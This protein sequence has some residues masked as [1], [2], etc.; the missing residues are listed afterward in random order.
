MMI[1]N[2]VTVPGSYFIKTAQRDYNSPLRA[3]IREFL[4]N[5]RDAGATEIKFN[6]SSS[7]DNSTELT[8]TDNGCGMDQETIINKLM[9]LGET[10]KGE[11]HV[12]GFGVA[13][14]LL[15][16]CHQS[17]TI[18][19]K[20][21]LVTGSGGTYTI[22]SNNNFI[23]GVKAS[24]VIAPEL[25]TYYSLST[26]IYICQE[27]IRKSYL[28][29]LT[30]FVQDE[31]VKAEIKK[32]KTVE[33]VSKGMTI[34]K[35]ITDYDV[36][37]AYVRVNGLFMFDYYVNKGR[38]QLIVELDGYSTEY[39]TTNRDGL[40]GDVSD[41]VRKILNEYSLNSN[42]GDKSEVKLFEGKSSR[43]S[44]K[45]L[46][47]LNQKIEELV[48]SGETHRIDEVFEETKK[49]IT[50]ELISALIQLQVSVKRRLEVGTTWIPLSAGDIELDHHY[51]VEIRGS[52][53]KLPAKW[54]PKNFKPSQTMTLELWSSILSMVLADAGHS[55][56][57]FN[58]GFIL[59]DGTE[60][61]TVLA[62]F[63]QKDR[64]FLFLLNPQAYGEEGRLPIKRSRRIELIMWLLNVAVHEV[65]H[66]LSCNYHNEEFISAECELKRKCFHRIKAYLKL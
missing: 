55:E 53:R 6:F 26:I 56:Q 62:N 4:Q 34:H 27:E 36:D 30:I 10:T 50:P 32:G 54:E 37:H 46:A 31:E 14:I 9:A 44:E 59:D 39:L 57:E 65:T 2:N 24:L 58:V 47:E 51:F 41:K 66:S 43:F 1:T 28:P 23:N 48:E 35:R 3:L 20:N 61:G 8:V 29:S 25:T 40:R 16:F 15:F 52:H 33:E 45:V 17:Y 21:L 7:P 64:G 19:T 42:K 11:G 63:R 38:F 18:E 12:G 5:S 49:Q 22:Q 13:K 60:G